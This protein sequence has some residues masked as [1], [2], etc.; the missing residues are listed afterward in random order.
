MMKDIKAVA[1][2]IDG[3]LYPAYALNILVIPHF[4]VNMRF[5]ILFN[6]VRNDL[7]KH[8]QLQNLL[9]FQAQLLSK[10]L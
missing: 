5:F 9:E 1:F 10:L 2:D 7:R 4:L 6:K 8:A 3:T